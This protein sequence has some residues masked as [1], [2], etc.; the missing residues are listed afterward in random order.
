MYQ[1]HNIEP[2]TS[3][4]QTMLSIGSRLLDRLNIW[5]TRIN[6]RRE[7]A[8]LDERILIDAGMSRADVL[9][10]SSKPFWRA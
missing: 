2:I 10:E 3:P 5:Q 9:L 4:G 8:R 1:V 7:L 6:E